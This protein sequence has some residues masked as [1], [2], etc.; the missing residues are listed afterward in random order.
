[1]ND[2]PLVLAD[3]LYG[4]AVIASACSAA[5]VKEPTDEVLRDLLA[6]AEA[7][8]DTRFEGVKPSA[9]LKQRYYDR[10]FV[11][12]SPYF[13]PL[14]EC[15]VREA[16]EDDGR[17]MYAPVNGPASD[18]V[19]RCYRAVGFDYRSIKGFD[20]AVKSLKPDSMA[21]EL[22]FIAALTQ[23][24]VQLDGDA[25]AKE[26]AAQLLVQFVSEHPARWFEKAADCL[27]RTEDDF[28]AKVCDL[29]A[30]TVA[31]LASE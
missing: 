20:L 14:F 25:A 31:A 21:S 2:A 6:V 12:A 17:M 15:S 18:H 19:L 1:M 3:Q 13:V 8:G 23:A 24:A 22:A 28:Y 4:C 26:R 9:Q 10:F 29:A 5:L 30:G 11:S 7:L 16:G 27:R